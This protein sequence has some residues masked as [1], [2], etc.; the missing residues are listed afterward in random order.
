MTSPQASAP[1]TRRR[2]TGRL[3]RRLAPALALLLVALAG[4]VPA[5]SADVL[6]EHLVAD[7]YVREF[8]PLVLNYLQT[9]VD[10]SNVLIGPDKISPLY[11]GV[12]AINDD[13]LYASAPVDL[14]GEPVIVTV[15]STT[16][17]YSVLVL[18]PFGNIY[19]TTLPG[20]PAGTPYPTTTYA[21][22]PPGFA[23]PLPPGVEQVDMPLTF[24]M[25]I[26]RVD[27]YLPDGTDVTAGATA[28]RAALQMRTSSAYLLDPNTG[29][30]RIFPVAAFAYPVKIIADD[31]VAADAIEFLR[32][33]QEAVHSSNTPPLSPAAQALSDEFDALF[34]TGSFADVARR[35]AFA[36][37]ARAAHRAIIDNYLATR[38][39]TNWTHFTNIGNWGDAVTDRSSIAEFCQYCNGIDTAAYY[40]AFYD[41]SGA[42]LVGMTPNGYTI[43]FPAGTQ[44]QAARFWSITAYTPRAI[45]PIPNDADKYEVASYTPGL[46]TAPDGSV[47]I[48]VA[49]TRPAGVPEAN[50]L[51]V[52]DDQFNLMLR[53]YGVVKDSSVAKNTYLP[54]AVEP[55]QPPPP[56]PPPPAPTPAAQPVS[57]VPPY[58]G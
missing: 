11:Q 53:V 38:G 44:P 34:G 3:S 14:S 40:H 27:K 35:E 33:L 39:S 28:F 56:P 54:P 52:G 45:Q 23:G 13:T 43:T 18:D 17:G 30:T 31:L 50:W 7:R 58:T 57:A 15:P 2:V 46:V 20:H 26:F 8:Y 36:T 24:Q 12:V 22:V 6:P 10:S 5:A 42:D 19:D 51:P 4:L 16:N 49:K 29:Q 9:R 55:Y 47:T 1:P 25:V 41:G 32:L 21:L 48:Y 37:G